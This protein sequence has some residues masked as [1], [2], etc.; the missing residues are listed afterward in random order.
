VQNFLFA[1]LSA[2]TL[3]RW[4]MKI[5]WVFSF[6]FFLSLLINADSFA[7]NYPRKAIDIEQYIE[8]MFQQQ[9][10]DLNYEDL[11]E[12]YFLLFT[13]PLNLNKATRDELVSLNILSEL[14]INALLD[15]KKK[16]G[17]FLSVYE[18]QA[19][20]YFDL[21]TIYKLLP[22]ITV[23]DDGLQADTRS[24]GQRI[25]TEHNHYFIMRTD[26]TI[27]DRAG[28]LVPEGDT[29]ANGNLRSRYVGSP[30]RTYMR[31]RLS[32]P[33]DFSFGFTAEKDPGEQFVVNPE[34]RQ[35]GMDFYSFHLAFFNKGKIKSAVIGDY[36]IQIGQGLLLSAGFTVGKSAETVNTIR[37]SNLGIKPYT[38]VLETG[39]M[40][41]GAVNLKVGKFEVMPFVSYLRED[42][43]IRQ[44]VIAQDSTG[45]PGDTDDFDGIDQDNVLDYVSAI[46]TSGLH[47][48][49]NELAARKQVATFTTGAT[50]QYYS[51]DK[52][53]N[54][55]LTGLFTRYSVPINRNTNDY[56]QFEFSGQENALMSFNYSYNW[57]NFNFFGENGISSSGGKGLVNGVLA[58]VSKNID[59]ALH[60]RYYDPNFHTF[61]GNALAENSRAINEA[62]TY[63]GIKIRPNK[64]WAMAAYHDSFRFHW[65]RF[66]A[67]APARGDEYLVRITHTPTRKINIYGQYRRESKGLNT[68]DPDAVID[69]ISQAIRSNYS[70][71]IGIKTADNITLKSRIQGSSF[72]HGT[73]TTYGYAIMQDVNFEFSKFK[74]ATRFALFDTDDYE[75]RQF[76]YEKDVLY[77][78]A[79]PA[80]YGLGYRAYCLV[81]CRPTKRMTLWVKYSY[82]NYRNQSVIS[83]GL[84][85]IEGSVRSDV[86]MQLRYFIG[87]K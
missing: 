3:F 17:R 49:A 73:K 7:Q 8:E 69:Y 32:H 1:Y 82:T 5:K 22:F 38:S 61:Y 68:P 45:T 70:F 6:V 13:S 67:D 18:L 36:R 35:Y 12:S 28:Y 84:E 80:Y 15:H 74:I 33:Q 37:R 75:N 64:K 20:E 34:N 63:M 77:A 78:F 58:S 14:Q 41:G 24:L 27:Q 16:H 51:E 72:N 42:G 21:K 83:S 39:F 11:Y 54:I 25:K 60:T 62:G 30:W 43:I 23:N 48:T 29:L 57:R 26:R 31:Y 52:T 19:V 59:F 71:N 53:L 81:E 87:A 2:Q 46:Q 44:Q 65:L 86:R 56:N 76:A 55:G 47:R 66:R 9:D 4:S 79:I 10:E 50:A 85:K 40:R